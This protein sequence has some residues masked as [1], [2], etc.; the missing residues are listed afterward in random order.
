[1][2]PLRAV[3]VTKSIHSTLFFSF[4]FLSFFFVFFLFFC[5]VEIN[6][7]SSGSQ[8]VTPSGSES[9]RASMDGMEVERRMSCQGVRK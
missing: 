4:F 7:N 1:M 8:G 5:M 9:E 3:T 2:S 6:I